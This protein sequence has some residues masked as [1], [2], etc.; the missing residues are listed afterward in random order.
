MGTLIGSVL[1]ADVFARYLRLK[2]HDVV[3]VSGSDEHGTPIEIE[4]IKRGVDFKALTDQYHS[5]ITKLFDEFR[6]SF[7]NYT[8]THNPIHI[9]FC[10]EFFMKLYE[11][12]YIFTKEVRQLYCP[13][14]QRFLPDRFV[15]GTCPYCGYE[16]ARG[17]QCD[18]CGRVLDPTDLINP[19][20]SICGSEPVVKSSKHWFFD[21][22]KFSDRLKKWLESNPRLPANARH[23]SLKWLE[24]G[25]KP[26]A[27]TR[28]NKWGI[29]A[30]FPGAEDKTIYV[31][32][33]AVLGYVTATIEWA[34]KKGDQEL[35]KDYWMDPE[36]RSVYFIGKDNIPF[37]TIIF[38]A[39]LLATHEGYNLPWNVSTN[40][41]LNFEGQKSSKSRK[42]GIWIDEALEMFHV[43]YW[44]YTLMANRPET[45][46]TNFTWK[47][48][49]ERVNSDLNDTLGNFIH[50]TLTFINNY[51]GGEIP[52]PEKLD[53]LDR[54]MLKTIN[55]YFKRID[56]SLDGFYIQ[57]A[58][59]RIIELAREG[60]KYLNE[61][62]PWKTIKSDPQSAA[63]A[64]Y[65]AA[66]IVKVL[67]V[68]LEPFMPL[69]AE[70]IRKCM[71]LPSDLLW[72]D[73]VDPI[74]AGHKIN[75]AR[76]I[77]EKINASEEE[78]QE[79]L[80]E[81][82]SSMQKI[83]F[84]EFS[85]VDMR[86]GKIIAAEKVP[87]SKNLLKLTIDI[88]AASPKTAVAGIAKY[89][90]P[91]ELV[92]QQIAVVVNLE[93]RKIFGIESEVMIL[94]AQHG[95]NVVFLRPEKPIEPGSKIR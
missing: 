2:G 85:K 37:H 69:A 75:E 67:A 73:A 19:R 8:R 54:E 3:F 9:K 21:L 90:K 31:W 70:K 11:K 29:P 66:Q 58:T 47:I 16:K 30:P 95:D 17:D 41:W 55:K 22:P 86:V 7:D 25:L 15:E 87:Q 78:L 61:K 62:K 79:M 43:D 63:V 89:Y 49:L 28:D 82:R 80:E 40:E 93:P 64:L 51:Y 42:I 34:A 72:K 57:A 13:K 38:P 45:S 10:Q 59:R 68:V 52:K 65:I 27:V 1:S 53:D 77:F 44:R 91:E 12:G 88:G 20:C 36:T 94:A 32:F 14:C 83:S 35:W 5:L 4:A 74:E 84:E 81:V 60:N 18:A 56:E 33:E 48:F 71:N 92:D 24:E 23:F 50:R 76:P 6:I 46:D 39:L 26:R